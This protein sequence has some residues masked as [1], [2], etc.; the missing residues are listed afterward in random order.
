MASGDTLVVYTA[1]DNQPQPT[2]FATLDT[3]NSHLVLDFD[4]TTQESAVFEGV[5]PRNYSGGGITVTCIWAATSATTGS[6][7]WA[8]S[9]ERLDD[10]GQDIDANGFAASQQATGAAPAN[11]GDLQY[12]AITYTNSQIA[13]LLAGEA[14]RLFLIRF[15]ED[16][17]DDMTG[18]AELLRIEMRET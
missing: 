11:N 9:W 17:G 6:V 16:V 13:G 15:V 7:V 5:L 12:T 8:A 18:D 10:E 2:A 1:R 3:R 4:A 14:F